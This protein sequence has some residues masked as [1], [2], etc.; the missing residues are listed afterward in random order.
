MPLGIISKAY[1]FRSPT[2][3]NFRISAMYIHKTGQQGPGHF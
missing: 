1:L 2:I 3:G